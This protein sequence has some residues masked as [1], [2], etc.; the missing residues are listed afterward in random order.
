ML[1]LSYLAVEMRHGKMGEKIEG[2]KGRSQ[3]ENWASWTGTEKSLW[4][5]DYPDISAIESAIRNF[6]FS[7]F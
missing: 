3:V 4:R 7:F 5:R 1:G 2:T 6:F